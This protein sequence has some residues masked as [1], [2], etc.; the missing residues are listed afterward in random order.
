MP[1]N[2]LTISGIDKPSDMIT[3]WNTNIVDLTEDI[4]ALENKTSTIAGEGVGTEGAQQ[5]MEKTMISQHI[6]ASPYTGANDFTFHRYD[7]STG[8]ELFQVHTYDEGGTFG[9]ITDIKPGS[10]ASNISGGHKDTGGVNDI[11][12]LVISGG[13]GVRPYISNQELHIEMEPTMVLNASGQSFVFASAAAKAGFDFDVNGASL[14]RNGLVISDEASPTAASDGEFTIKSN[15]GFA[16]TLL[17]A[18]NS[19]K[20]SIQLFNVESKKFSITKDNNDDF[21]IHDTD[22]SNYALVIDNSNSGH[23]AINNSTV[24]ADPTIPF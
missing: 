3:K 10:Q 7:F 6:D 20:A 8:L 15:A 22:K 14:F 17:K 1:Q 21:Y 12:G 24:A 9:M 16:K 5:I 23:V 13:N 19:Q 11:Y 2:Y 18:A 4:L